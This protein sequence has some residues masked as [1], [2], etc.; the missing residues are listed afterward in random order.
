MKLHPL[1]GK[2]LPKN[3]VFSVIGIAGQKSSSLLTPFTNDGYYISPRYVADIIEGDSI[4]PF[5]LLNPTNNKSISLVGNPTDQI[6]FNWQKAKSNIVGKEPIYTFELDSLSGDFTK[7]ILHLVSQNLGKDT[8][9]TLGLGAI[10]SA[11][12]LKEGQAI[13]AKWRVLAN[14]QANQI[15]SNS[16]FQITFTRGKFNTIEELQHKSQISLFPNPATESITLQTSETE[17]E[18]S[19]LQYIGFVNLTQVI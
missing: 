18:Y 10:S 3:N 17:A 6:Q 9:I 4:L 2:T 19:S 11:L 5:N 14:I 15:H 12:N 8:S 1:I 16:T 13:N 7:P